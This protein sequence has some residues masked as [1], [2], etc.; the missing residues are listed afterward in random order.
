[1]DEQDAIEGSSA[2]LAKAAARWTDGADHATTA[3]ADLEF[4]RRDSASD[5]TACVVEPSVA[6]VVQGAKSMSLGEE[7][8]RYDPRRFLITSL[9]LPATMQVLE[10]SRERPYLGVVLKLDLRVVGELLLRAPVKLARENGT[11]RGMALGHVTP[12][13][14]DAFVR[15]V[16]LLDEPESIAVLAPMIQREICWR[17]LMSEQGARLRQMVSAGS[18]T[19]RIAHAIEWMKLHYSEPL[20]VEALA[21]RAQMSPSTF[22]HHFRELTA[23][24]PLQYQKRLRLTEARRIMLGEHVDAASAAYRTGYESPSQFS[25]EYSRLFGAPPRQDIEAQRQLA[26]VSARSS[27][28]ASHHTQAL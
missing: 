3:I 25:R 14:L 5:C 28:R 12:A 1:M 7:I 13:L 9:D 18:Q 11:A 19:H 10:A 23:L 17:V 2:R 6:L 24:S 15:L 22:H 4:Y 8:Y 20:R 26:T 27:K 16:A 21:Q